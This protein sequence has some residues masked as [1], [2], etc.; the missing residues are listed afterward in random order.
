VGALGVPVG[1][2]FH[3]SSYGY[4][5]GY[6]DSFCFQSG[7]G[8]RRTTT[9]TGVFTIH[10]KTRIRNILDGTSNTFAIGEAAAGFD[11]CSGLG[12]TTPDS[13]PDNA[14]AKHGWLVGGQNLEN[15]YDA[16]FRYSGFW[17]S[18]VEPI[19]K[20]PATDSLF[21]STTAIFDCTPSWQG[22]PHWAPNFRSFHTGGA[23]FLFC[24]GSVRFLNENMNL[25]NYRAMSTI[26]GGEIVSY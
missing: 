20:W 16:G 24:D 15:L 26:Q 25:Q 7:W 21:R 11:M 6:D 22:G 18:T 8:T 13:N 14:I 1:D 2:T 5:V 19:N 17:G 10:S 9:N 23:F 3:N 4:S 12:C